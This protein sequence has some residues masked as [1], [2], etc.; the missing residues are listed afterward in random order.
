MGRLELMICFT[1]NPNS[2]NPNLKKGG[3]LEEVNFLKKE[4][5]S[6]NLFFFLFF[7]FWGGGGE[8]EGGGG[9]GG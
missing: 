6:K 8:R 3:G 5:L 7:F 4:S 9:V 1:T 2:K